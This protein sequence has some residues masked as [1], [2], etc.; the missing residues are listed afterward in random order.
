MY[1]SN[2]EEGSLQNSLFN[3]LAGIKVYGQTHKNKNLH[4]KT[5]KL[6]AE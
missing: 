4:K 1:P 5:K 6:A 2:K 3:T